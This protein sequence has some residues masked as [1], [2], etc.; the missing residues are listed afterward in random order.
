MTWVGGGRSCSKG[1]IVWWLRTELVVENCSGE[2]E[3]D[4][5]QLIITTTDNEKKKKKRKSSLVACK[6]TD[7][8]DS[9]TGQQCKQG[10]QRLL[11]GVD[12][13]GQGVPRTH[14][15]IWTSS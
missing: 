7:D 14:H 1:G 15:H 6:P 13:A 8:D 5:F 11:V 2:R 3:K 9:C 10:E 12:E 4:A